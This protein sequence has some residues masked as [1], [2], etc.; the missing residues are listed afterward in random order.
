MFSDSVAVNKAAAITQA[1]LLYVWGNT[2]SPCFLFGDPQQLPLTVM[3]L[4]EIWSKSEVDYINHFALDLR[5]SALEYLQAGGIPV[6]RLKMQLQIGIGMFD[7]VLSIIYPDV[8]FTY[9]PSRAIN[10]NFSDFNV[11]RD[12]ESFALERYPALT[13][14][15]KDTLKPFF[16]YCEG[17]RVIQ[18]EMSGSKRSFDQVQVATDFIVDFVAVKKVPVAPYA[19]NVD[20]ING[21]L[22]RSKYI[23]LQ[24]MPKPSTID[25]FQGQE[26]DII[27]GVMGTDEIVGP[28]FTA[29]T[30]RLNV[31]L[32][33]AK[34]G[35]V[36][37]G[38]I[39]VAQAVPDPKKVAAEAKAKA[40][41]E[42]EA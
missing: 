41:A 6:Y 22:K 16:I 37:V 25:S 20:L 23:S 8:P 33:R 1:D 35:L 31:T 29:A 24:G 32:T 7:T 10:I 39:Y 19:A 18:D 5:I 21:L 9:D 15:P 42:E 11:S 28:G 38:N 12:L 30:N 27:I 17:G 13:P 14:A 36:L 40:L 2:L 4:T 34:C 3:M 26:N